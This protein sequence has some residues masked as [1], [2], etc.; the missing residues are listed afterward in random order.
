MQTLELSLIDVFII[1]DDLQ[2]TS[3]LQALDTMH[4][5]STLHLHL[6]TLLLYPKDTNYTTS[7]LYMN[8]YE[9]VVL[10]LKQSHLTIINYAKMI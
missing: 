1:V 9:Y 5:I 6:S 7:V 2:D 8:I 10:H 3:L 4:H